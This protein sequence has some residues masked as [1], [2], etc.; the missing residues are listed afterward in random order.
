MDPTKMVITNTH[1]D[2]SILSKLIEKLNLNIVY[3]QLLPFPRYL[4]RN[5][6]N[7]LVTLINEIIDSI[8]NNLM[9][10][11]VF[12]ENIVFYIPN[13]NFNYFFGLNYTNNMIEDNSYYI[14][15]DENELKIHIDLKEYI[16]SHVHTLL[17]VLKN[18]YP[19]YLK[20]DEV[21]TIDYMEMVL[22]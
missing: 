17:Y 14:F 9:I 15:L 7:T 3:N 16:D 19:D 10:L 1:E 18:E 21:D 6:S 12:N 5:I 8:F 13:S 4:R 20:P 22:F 2:D 11:D